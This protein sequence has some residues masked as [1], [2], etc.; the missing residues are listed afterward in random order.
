MSARRERQS[1]MED[2]QEPFAAFVLEALIR[3]STELGRRW[4]EQAQLAALYSGE[5]DDDDNARTADTRGTEQ[6]VRTLLLA[7]TDG[8]RRHDILIQ[9]G[10]AIGA[11][12]HRQH[13]SLQL[14]LK[15][16]DLLGTL[17]L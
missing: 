14:M 8:P 5:L 3:E 13:A 16:L 15:E 6:L 1:S 12:A 4:A 7:A 2:Q 9:T 11:K 17:L 10:V